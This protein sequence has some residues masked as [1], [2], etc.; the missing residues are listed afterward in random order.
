MGVSPF[1]DCD[2]CH[3]TVRNIV[4]PLPAAAVATEAEFQSL[5]LLGSDSEHVTVPSTSALTPAQKN[6]VHWVD[7]SEDKKSI[8]GK[9]LSN[10]ASPLVLWSKTFSGPILEIA[11]RP[12]NE[13]VAIGAIK[14]GTKGLLLKYLNSNLMS[15][16]SDSSD[17]VDLTILD[18]AN[19][20]VIHFTHIADAAGP[21]LVR[22]NMRNSSI[23]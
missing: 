23:D 12:A 18:G 4:L 21:I 9:I 16:V 6:N 7:L 3:L 17:G 15:V 19:G 22:R 2:F 13:V 20:N 10:G 14:L 5:L 8:E 1:V 11:R